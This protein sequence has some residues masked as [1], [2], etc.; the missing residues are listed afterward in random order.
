MYAADRALAAGGAYGGSYED[1]RGI[2]VV[3]HGGNTFG[4]ASELAFVPELDMGISVLTNPRHAPLNTLV[5]AKLLELLLDRPPQLEDQLEFQ[6]GLIEESHAEEREALLD[7]IDPASVD[8]WLGT[9]RNEVLGELT[10]GLED[11]ALLIGL[12]RAHFALG[13]VRSSQAA[14]GP[15]GAGGWGPA[16]LAPVRRFASSSLSET[17]E[18]TVKNAHKASS[19]SPPPAASEP[20]ASEPTA[21]NPA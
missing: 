16:P 11:D 4:L 21:S 19:P 6:R 13:L 12:D 7:A 20:L 5:R 14:P 1:D 9:F 17:S 15:F 3:S 8:P 18:P 2:E 10:L